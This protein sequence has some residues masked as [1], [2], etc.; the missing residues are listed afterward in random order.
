MP[1]GG[2]PRI[3]HFVLL[4][5][6]HFVGGGYRFDCGDQ[7][8]SLSV[9]SAGPLD[10]KTIAERVRV[11][12]LVQDSAI[13]G[14]FSQCQKGIKRGSATPLLRGRRSEVSD[15]IWLTVKKVRTP[16][17]QGLDPGEMA[18]R[19]FPFRLQKSRK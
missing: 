11:R 1:S 6:N 4:S 15:Q 17:L 16:R 9:T 8:K 18:F 12:G 3:K 14:R 5:R 13:G 7:R 19:D 2:L 10:K